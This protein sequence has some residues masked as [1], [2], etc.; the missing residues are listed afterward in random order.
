MVASIT[1]GERITVE[2][3]IESR[4]VMTIS[5][6]MIIHIGI[7]SETSRPVLSASTTITPH[8]DRYPPCVLRKPGREQIPEGKVKFAVE[9]KDLESDKTIWALYERWCEAFN[10]KLDHDEKDRWFNTFKK[11]VLHIHNKPNVGYRRGISEF[12]D[13]KLRKPYC[14]DLLDLKI[15]KEIDHLVQAIVDDSGKLYKRVFADY[16]LV[17]DRLYVHLPKGG[18]VKTI[19]SDP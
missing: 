6:A 7:T 12:A 9:E 18:D 2:Q 11:T 14:S 15:A 5:K 4:K 1:V 13:G 8:I 17:Q 10:H 3:L 16:K 19:T